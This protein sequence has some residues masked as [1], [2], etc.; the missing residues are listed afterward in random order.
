MSKGGARAGAGRKPGS[1]TALTRD[2]A[3]RLAKEGKLPL[4]VMVETMRSLWNDGKK[5]EA[6]QIAEKAAP[7][8]HP[9]LA[10]VEHSGELEV[11]RVVRVP[12]QSKTTAEWARTHVPAHMNPT[13]H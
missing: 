6:C 9:R 7:Y 4:E 2:A 5:L 8:M 1:K 3:E 12:D 10:A 13:E 11:S